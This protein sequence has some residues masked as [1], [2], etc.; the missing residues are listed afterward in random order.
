MSTER[1]EAGP[2][3]VERR[4]LQFADFRVDPVRRLLLRD[5][6]PLPITSK[7][8]STL[9]V[10][11]EGRGEVI[12]KGDLI[13]RVWGDTFVTEANLTQNVSSLRKVLGD[14]NGERRIIVTSPGI[15]YAF[16]AEVIEVTVDT[17]SLDGTGA[18][19]AVQETTTQGSEPEAGPEA[20]PEVDPHPGSEPAA[21]LDAPVEPATPGNDPD[22]RSD[23]SDRTAQIPLVTTPPHGRRSPLLTPW[24]VALLLAV[25]AL[26]LLVGNLVLRRPPEPD[27]VAA[28]PSSNPRPALAVL[29]FKDL[30]GN[31]ETAWLA[32]A[33]SEMLTTEL[34]AGSQARLISGE[35]V[36]RARRS[37]AIPYT[38]QLTT[39]AMGQLR[40]VLGAD[41]VVLG[42]YLTLNGPSGPQ[43]RLDLR[44][45][46]LPEGEAVASLSEVGKQADLFEMVSRIGVRLRR[47]LGL[48]G[49][50]PSE[51][52][53]VQA[54]HPENPEAARLH[55]EALARLRASNPLEARDLLEKAVR[56]EPASAV[57]HS[58][59]SRAWGDLG[60]DALAREE[61]GKAADLAGSLPRPQRLAI[62]ARFYES[63]RKWAEAAEIYRSLW[64]FYPD[65]NEYGLQLAIALTNAGRGTEAIEIFERLRRTPSG[66]DDPRIDIEEARTASRLSDL[67]RQL[68][69]AG[70]G[71]EKAG[72]SGERL[73]QARALAFEGNALHELG[74]SA[75]ALPLFEKAERLARAVGEPWT[76]GMVLSN[77]AAGLKA[78]GRLEDSAVKE[79]ESLAIAR[80]IGSASGIA[81]Q[82][83]GLAVLQQERGHLEEALRYMRESYANYVETGDVMMQGRVLTPTAR[84]YIRQGDLTG[85]RRT[86]EE[87]LTAARQ[88]RNPA[89]EAR[90]LDTLATVLLWQDDLAA[91]REQQEAALHLMLGLKMPAIAAPFLAASADTLDRLGDRATAERRRDQALATEKRGGDKMSSGQVFGPLVRVGL[92]HGDLAAART[93]SEALLL[94][95]RQTGSRS[96]QAWGL[97]E[98]G[99]VQRNAG[100]LAAARAS[101][102]S[103]LRESTATGDE[104]RSW[105]TRLEVARLEL[106]AGRTA[107]AIALSRSAA[108]WFAERGISGMQAQALGVTAEALLR[109][110][111]LAEAREAAERLRSLVRSSQDRELI[112]SAASILGRVDAAAGRVDQAGRDLRV[113]I[114][115][116]EQ[117]GLLLASFEAR[118]VLAELELGSG[119]RTQAF[120]DLRRDAEAR[121]LGDL[122]R[123][124]AAA[125]RALPPTPRVDIREGLKG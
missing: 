36:T 43:I 32:T 50:R 37:L 77:H 48:D 95:A 123:R 118:L 24:R 119:R 41:M 15:G 107:E 92:R 103:S 69:T 25:V 9:L 30:S 46:K 66:R 113:A 3:L 62:Q 89:D 5:G 117:S 14:R 12:E 10:L 35:N 80:Q 21:V 125:E 26:S 55:A 111:R 67:D 54:L 34:S 84:L 90:A 22:D 87:A 106:S 23:R 74:R 85:A 59:L 124:V 51:A 19:L 27:V 16:M 8:F 18:G 57:I 63:G 79:T 94:L 29:G 47:E 73:A 116:A 82:L 31:Q 44:V 110:G 28:S 58:L 20:D 71:A 115:D 88:V 72:R 42:S 13:R 38:D 65:D 105:V 104:L 33:L 68:R 7:A 53:A 120:Q 100:D 1:P 98:L 76:I 122:A 75:E 70:A 112:T 86:A 114:A 4:L 109:E 121:G 11:L 61:A 39:R 97:Q 83:Y 49:L 78:L 52:R 81:Y 64:T 101:F 96:L 102:A 91:A 17:D 60:Y 6:E 108:V 56:I 99:R 40:T 45:L 2:A 93:Q